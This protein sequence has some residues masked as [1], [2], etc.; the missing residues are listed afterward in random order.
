MKKYFTLN[1]EFGTH[2]G[3][4]VAETSEELTSKISEAIL[5]CYEIPFNNNISFDINCCDNGLVFQFMF[6][7]SPEL[8]I[9]PEELYLESTKIY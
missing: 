3:T 6:F 7:G 9:E 5:E 4:I 1:G 8:V 2:V